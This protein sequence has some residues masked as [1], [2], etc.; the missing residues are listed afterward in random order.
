MKIVRPIHAN[1]GDIVTII[2]HG[3]TDQLK[4]QHSAPPPDVWKVR[5]EQ[6]KVVEELKRKENPPDR[7]DT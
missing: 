1:V 3:E 2:W 4:E 7:M 6:A 5:V